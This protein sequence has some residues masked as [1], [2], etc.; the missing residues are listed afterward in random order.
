MSYHKLSNIYTTDTGESRAEC[1]ICGDV[2]ISVNRQRGLNRCCEAM[3]QSYLKKKSSNTK[4]IDRTRHRL[5]DIDDFT[6]TAIC[7]Q[8]GEVDFY[9]NPLSGDYVCKTKIGG[10]KRAH[11][12]TNQE[13]TNLRNEKGKCDICS[14]TNKLRVDHDHKTMAIRGVLCHKCNSAIGMFHDSPELLRQAIAYLE[15]GEL[16]GE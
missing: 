16:S 13:A 14:S 10:F 4:T 1:S 8:C 12:L 9:Y 11:G 3:H 5:S 15:N 2:K 6:K 7:S